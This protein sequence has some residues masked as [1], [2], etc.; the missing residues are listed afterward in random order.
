VHAENQHTH[1]RETLLEYL[2]RFKPVHHRHGD[3]HHHHIRLQLLS[4][5]QRLLAIVRQPY[6][7]QMGL[8]AKPR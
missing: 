8:G 6:N 5:L 1:R 4:Q 3:I 7:V 2:G